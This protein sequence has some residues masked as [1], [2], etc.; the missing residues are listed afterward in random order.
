MHS[1]DDT[2]VPAWRV[3]G[4]IPVPFSDA[5]AA[6]AVAAREALI[7]TA[8]VYGSLITQAELGFQVQ[9]QTG[10]KAGAPVR[11]WIA[12]LLGAVTEGQDDGEPLLASL[13]VLL[14]QTAGDAYAHALGV[15][16][17][18]VPA[19]LDSDAAHV[20][21]RCYEFFGATIPA[22]ARPTLA[23]RVAEKR[24]ARGPAR[25]PK[26]AKS[27]AK[28]AK[29]A[30]PGTKPAAAAEPKPKKA[31]AKPKADPKPE[32]PKP[33]LCPNCFTVLSTSGECGFCY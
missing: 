22:G 14:D 28:A 3:A 27:P 32:E 5:L 31:K 12:D 19:D 25:P 15:A 23:P 10:I 26:A 2:R 1:D 21:F 29:S 33:K 24:A 8:R 9:S 6:W 16:G 17:R 13:C 20:R 4:E 7:E 30:A 11:K 18:S